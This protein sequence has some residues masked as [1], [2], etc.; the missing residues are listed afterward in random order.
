M[1]IVPK[2]QCMLYTYVAVCKK[3]LVTQNL[4][5]PYIVPLLRLVSKGLKY[6]GKKFLQ[7]GRAF[8]GSKSS[9]D[10]HL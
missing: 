9:Q 1:S 5:M 6:S 7:I 2:L 8:F 4:R 10:S 3:S